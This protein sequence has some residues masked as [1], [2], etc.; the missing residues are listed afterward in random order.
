[1]NSAA[2]PADAASCF[3]QLLSSVAAKYGGF[4]AHTTGFGSRMMARWGFGGAGAGLG[5]SQQ[6]APPP[7]GH[8]CQGLGFKPCR[9]Q[10]LCSEDVA[11]CEE[12]MSWHE[13]A[14]AGAM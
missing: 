1:M 10:L 13:M 4:E 6:G 9:A 12:S 5:A 11:V 7:P 3:L 8:A 14:A 2:N